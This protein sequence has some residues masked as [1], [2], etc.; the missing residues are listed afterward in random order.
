MCT[1]VSWFFGGVSQNLSSFLR[2]CLRRPRTFVIFPRR[3]ART[4]RTHSGVR[5]FSL[6]G[7]LGGQTQKTHVLLVLQT[8]NA[9]VSPFAPWALA[10]V[11]SLPERARNQ[12]TRESVRLAYLRKRGIQRQKKRKKRVYF[13]DF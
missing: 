7:K 1:C 8:E 6:H 11:R 9:Q 10:N 13:F 3:K 2:S 12:F 4:K 5:A